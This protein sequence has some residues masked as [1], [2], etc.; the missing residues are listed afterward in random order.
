MEKNQKYLVS[1]L[2]RFSH[3]EFGNFDSVDTLARGILSKNDL[4]SDIRETQ[5][6]KNRYL[7]FY[8][9]EDRILSQ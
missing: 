6:V 1:R 9:R 8:P 5:Y 2:A 7:Y 3:N 4:I